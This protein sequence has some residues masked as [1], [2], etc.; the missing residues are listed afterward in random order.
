MEIRREQHWE[1]ADRTVFDV[2]I[3]GG[4]VNGACLYHQLCSQGYKVLLTDKGDFACCSS[5]SSGMMIWGGL[6]YL[7]NLD[8]R[9]VYQLSKARDTMIT[10]MSDRVSPCLFRYIPSSEGD[11]NRQMIYADLYLYWLAGMFRRRAPFS[12]R[13]FTEAVLIQDV[14][15]K[16][17]FVYEEGALKGSDCRYGLRWIVPFQAPEHVPLNYCAVEGGSY[18]TK[19]KRWRLDLKDRLDN[20]EIQVT[21]WCVVNCA[22]VWVDRT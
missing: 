19:A 14:T 20:R 1:C 18:S 21:A 17:S 5:Q 12:Q 15:P 9:S 3:I 7:R 16:G 22:G 2:M 4:G 11:R 13:V 6:L 10:L 8:L